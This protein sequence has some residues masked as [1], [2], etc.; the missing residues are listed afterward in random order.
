MVLLF[1]GFDSHTA[2]QFKN[3]KFTISSLFDI[4]DVDENPDIKDIIDFNFAEFGEKEEPYFKQSLKVIYSMGL[5]M[6]QEKLMEEYKTETDLTK[7]RNIAM[8]L[9]IVTKELKNKKSGE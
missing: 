2:P 9:S 3:K 1:R 6:K 4:F 7:R 8:Q 5:K